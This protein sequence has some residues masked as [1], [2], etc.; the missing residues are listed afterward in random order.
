MA[1]GRNSLVVPQ[2]SA[3]LEQLKMEA[4]QELGVSIPSSGYYGD[5]TSREAGSLGGYIT[6]RLVQIAEQSLAGS[7]SNRI[8]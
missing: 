8:R 3:A 5:V 2:S 4:A 6:K 7:S 1:N